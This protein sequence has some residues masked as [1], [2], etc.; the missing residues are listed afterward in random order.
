MSAFESE[1]DASLIALDDGIDKGDVCEPL[2]VLDAFG[3]VF[4]RKSY[5]RR[6]G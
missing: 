4:V 2:G 3:S 5:S 1:A 6:A